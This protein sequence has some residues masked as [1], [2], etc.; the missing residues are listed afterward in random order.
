MMRSRLFS[1]GQ[2][3]ALMAN[4][5]LV[6]VFAMGVS[7]QAQTSTHHPHPARKPAHHAAVPVATTPSGNAF[8]DGIA[9]VVNSDVITTRELNDQLADVAKQMQSRNVQLPP[10]AVL[11][12]QVIEQMIN[13]SLQRQEAKAL[14]I[15][16][17]D[18]QLN[19]AIA[20]IAQ[21]NKISVD[22]MRKAIEQS[23]V[24]WPQYQK[25]IRDEIMFEE[26]R[27]RDVDSKIYIS[28]QEV[29]AYLQEQKQ[30]A[31]RGLPSLYSD[32]SQNGN[33]APPAAQPAAPQDAGVSGND[34]VGL[35][36]ILIELPDQPTSQQVAERRALAE[37]V[38]ARLKSGEDFASVAAAAS[39]ASGALQGGSLGQR[40]LQGWPD[41][42]VNAING[43][44][45]GQI[46]GIIQT[47]NG[48]HILQ[49]TSVRS[50]DG[51]TKPQGAPAQPA[52][53]GGAAGLQQQAD[54]GQPTGPMMVTQTHA[55]HI[56]IKTS[57]IRNDAQAKALLEQLR[58]RILHDHADFGQIAQE[59]SQD[60][61]APQG[62]DLGWLNP[63]E[64][65]PAFEQAMNALQPGEIS[66]PIQSQFGWHLIQV[67]GRRQ[68]DMSKEYQRL[69]ARKVLFEQR[70]EPAYEAWL[71]GLRSQAFIDNR[72][73]KDAAIESLQ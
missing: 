56:L 57:A 12:H 63:G 13:D 45:A 68:T 53:P 18:A 67:L 1:R 66:E 55:R 17:P 32:P 33:G 50:P 9:V 70:E 8:L 19:V 26:V 52:P 46:T 36:Q 51:H 7:A 58:N 37:K 34:I 48:F 47:G 71:Q 44:Q 40:P 61:N 60:S 35:A 11:Q 41:I 42:F 43:L 10:Q 38:L 49:V 29:D 54:A 6:A 27:R 64:T 3:V 15:T 4:A 72:L 14:G 73:E 5:A 30:R 31:A 65:V 28:D 25:S 23:G 69:N 20:S 24:T 22:G 16:V 21:R 2:H 62:G 39:N 59:Y